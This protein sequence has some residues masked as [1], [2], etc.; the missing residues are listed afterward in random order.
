MEMSI[1]SNC[2]NKLRYIYTKT[3]YAASKSPQVVKISY[4]KEV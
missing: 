3:Y 1:T 2:L 4:M